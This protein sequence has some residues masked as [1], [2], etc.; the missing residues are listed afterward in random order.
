MRAAGEFLTRLVS[1]CWMHFSAELES[2]HMPCPSWC[3][4]P[5]KEA[6][7]MWAFLA[8]IAGM[9]LALVKVRRQRKVREARGTQAAA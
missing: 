2:R 5:R 1:M 4:S 9:G 6:V 3:V 8:V 7:M